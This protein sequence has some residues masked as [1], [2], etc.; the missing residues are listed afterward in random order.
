MESSVFQ[1]VNVNLHW[2]IDMYVYIRSLAPNISS[3][4]YIYL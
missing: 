2:F 1:K 4:I 3:Y